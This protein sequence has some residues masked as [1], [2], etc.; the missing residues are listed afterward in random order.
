MYSVTYVFRFRF[1]KLLFRTPTIRTL[2]FFL[3][4]LPF[5][6]TSSD[7]LYLRKTFKSFP[8]TRKL[9]L[10]VRVHSLNVR[11]LPVI[12]SHRYASIPLSVPVSQ[13]RKLFSLFLGKYVSYAVF[14]VQMGL[15]RL[16]LPTSRL[17]GVRSNL[18]SYK[19]IMLAL[20]CSP[21]PSPARYH[22]P[23]RS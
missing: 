16:E 18:L 1:S 4:Q 5:K 17:S 6:I 23:H 20:S 12:H 8:G 22:R 10:L 19:P 3:C 13:A 2:V 7:V 14:K 15:S 9:R 11:F 21:G